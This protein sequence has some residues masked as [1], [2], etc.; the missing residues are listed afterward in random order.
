MVTKKNTLVWLQKKTCWKSIQLLI[1]FKTLQP[2]ETRFFHSAN[3][4]VHFKPNEK[5]LFSHFQV[6]VLSLLNYCNHAKK[7]RGI[8]LFKLKYEF[9]HWPHHFTK[10]EWI[11]SVSEK[12]RCFLCFMFNNF[13]L[14]S[15]SRKKKPWTRYWIQNLFSLFHTNKQ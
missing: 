3:W 11:P 9:C 6:M 4:F 8:I 7:T 1:K 15:F 13:P 14:N 2:F 5:N 10:Q 12:K